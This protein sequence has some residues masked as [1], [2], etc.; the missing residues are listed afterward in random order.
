[1]DAKPGAVRISPQRGV[2]TTMK[3]TFFLCPT[4][5]AASEQRDECHGHG[6]VRCEPGKPDDRRRRPLMDGEG[7]LTSH[8]P[9][10]FLEAV[11][12]MP[13]R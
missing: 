13:A 4:C 2:F 9:R 11:G 6:M 8:A 7:R 1:M 12:W 3:E 5:F 10:W